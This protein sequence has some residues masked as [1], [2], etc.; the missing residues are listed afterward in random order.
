MTY[1][2]KCMTCHQTLEKDLI[3]TIPVKKFSVPASSEYDIASI[4][5]A[6]K[7]N[8]WCIYLLGELLSNALVALS[9]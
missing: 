8:D 5:T 1:T 6:V 3:P 7:F 9:Q 4:H 2:D